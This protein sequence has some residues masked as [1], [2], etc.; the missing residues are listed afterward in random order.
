MSFAHGLC[1]RRSCALPGIHFR[2]AAFL[3]LVALLAARSS[4]QSAADPAPALL[5]QQPAPASKTDAAAKPKAKPKKVY[6]NDDLQTRSAQVEEASSTETDYYAG[7]L[8]CDASCEKQASTEISLGHDGISGPAAWEQAVVISRKRIAADAEWREQLRKMIEL[9]RI[10]C[11]YINP[12]SPK[13]T[14]GAKSYDARTGAEAEEYMK[15]TGRDLDASFQILSAQMRTRINEV[16]FPDP[17]T[18]ALMNV[19]FMRVSACAPYVP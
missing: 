9:M 5:E 1:D 15:R 4:A 14:P 12:Q 17:A 2:P 7:L 3:A 13:G 6:T 18:G 16:R 8:K 10:Y 19:Q 11:N